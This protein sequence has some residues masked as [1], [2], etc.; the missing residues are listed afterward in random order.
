MRLNDILT[1]LQAGY[2]KDDIQAMEA[3]E[4]AEPAEPAE[5]AKPAEPTEPAEPAEPAVS[6]G[7][8][9]QYAKLEKL[10]NQFINT[11]QASNLNANMAGAQQT[12]T[13]T[14]ILAG[15]IAPPR[16]DK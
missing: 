6:A 2:T 13:S 10:L 14:D 15:I 8:E 5:P 16:K 9:D 4:H 11:A 7:P 12:K 1:L 3:A